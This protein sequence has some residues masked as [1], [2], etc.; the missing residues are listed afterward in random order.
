MLLDHAE[1]IRERARLQQIEADRRES[2]ERYISAN[3]EPKV[4]N[5]KQCGG[6]YWD[7]NPKYETTQEFSN[8]ECDPKIGKFAQRFKCNICP[9]QFPS[10][11][12]LRDHKW[13]NHRQL[14]KTA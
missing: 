5:P 1:E 7:R 6:A 8:P 9:M 10:N 14:S 4:F 2:W 3:H 13:L 11:G 12:K